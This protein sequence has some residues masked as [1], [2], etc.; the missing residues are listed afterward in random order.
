MIERVF[1]IIIAL[2]DSSFTIESSAND[3]LHTRGQLI[4]LYPHL[5]SPII[6]VVIFLLLKSSFLKK[7]ILKKCN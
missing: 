5:I 7:I 4:Q 6:I 2:A 1:S 3:P